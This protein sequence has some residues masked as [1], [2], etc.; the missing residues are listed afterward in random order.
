MNSEVPMKVFHSFR[1]GRSRTRATVLSL[2]T[3]AIGAC[4]APTVQCEAPTIEHADLDDTPWDAGRWL[5]RCLEQEPSCVR[6]PRPPSESRPTQT[7]ASRPV[8]RQARGRNGL[9]QVQVDLGQG[10]EDLTSFGRVQEIHEAEVSPDG[11]WL[12]VWHHE[13]PPRKLTVY[14]LPDKTVAA[15]FAPGYGGSL[16]WTAANEILHY[17]GCGT[18][19]TSYAL[20]RHDGEQV[21]G[22][23]ATAMDLSPGGDLL[24]EFPV[25]SSISQAFTVRDLASHDVV[26][27]RRGVDYGLWV[28]KLEWQV[29]DRLSVTWGMPE[30]RRTCVEAFEFSMG[31]RALSR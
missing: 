22:G 18:E 14:V 29:E 31:E 20:Y 12:L 16:G 7:A 15:D 30:D 3:M 24:V 17:W 11:R 13:L 21:L 19:C 26:F 9:V 1:A 6:V 25:S 5:A 8:L 4:Q 10:F 28:K 27:S 23:V 2:V